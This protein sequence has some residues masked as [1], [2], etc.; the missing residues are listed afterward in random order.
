MPY[1][2]IKSIHMNFENKTIW[3]TGA[4]SGIGKALALK[5]SYYKVKLILSSR[6]AEKLEEVKALCHKPEN[7]KVLPMDLTKRQEAPKWVNEALGMFGG[8][9]LLINNAGISQ[10]SLAADTGI[11]VDEAIFSINY[12]GTIA[13]T[14]AMLPHFIKKKDGYIVVITSVV[15]RVG[16]PLR[17][18]Y[19]ASKHALHGF[20]DSLRAEVFNENI[21]ISLICPGFVN[22]NISM[23]ALTADGSEQKSMDEATAKGLSPEDFAN[24][25]VKAMKKEKQEVVIGRKLEALA[26]YL[27]R[28]FP[29]I[30][31]KL[32]RKVKVT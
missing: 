28:F 24:K 26:V 32:L 3:I 21:R 19:S 27:K 9:D 8:I 17:S 30:L 13:L 23:N 15:G 12:F 7:I 18:S 20:F 6:N 14:K 25:A 29:L 10:R 11:K 31:S 2:W 5:L 16:T 22:T 4:S 1:I